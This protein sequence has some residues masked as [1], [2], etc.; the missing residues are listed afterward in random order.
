MG[1]RGRRADGESVPVAGGLEGGEGAVARPVLE[2]L[3]M[4]GLGGRGLGEEADGGVERR[5][6]VLVYAPHA[7]QLVVAEAA[8]APQRHV[9]ER[10][11][12]RGDGG[13]ERAASAPRVAEE[14][15]AWLGEA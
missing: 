1:V 6:Q 7:Q 2:E 4:G 3:G 14:G 12:S 11:G 9:H 15:E 10:V 5:G 8:G 13:G